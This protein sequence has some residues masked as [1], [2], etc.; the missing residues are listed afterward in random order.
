MVMLILKMLLVIVIA[1][2]TYSLQYAKK[3][4]QSFRVTIPT[5]DVPDDLF[6]ILIAK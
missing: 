1:Y 3:W 6:K 2:L 4:G 5:K